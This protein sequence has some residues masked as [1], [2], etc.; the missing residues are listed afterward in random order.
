MSGAG[1]TD[2]PAPAPDP[3]LRDALEELVGLWR[4]SGALVPHHGAVGELVDAA[5]DLMRRSGSEARAGTAFEP[6][7]AVADLMRMRAARGEGGPDLSG[8]TPPVA[9]TQ[10]AAD[11]AARIAPLT[12]AAPPARPALPATPV[13]GW[14]AQDL[15]DAA[16]RFD[17]PFADPELIAYIL[18]VS[19]NA[20]VIVELRKAAYR[21]DRQTRRALFALLGALATLVRELADGPLKSFVEGI[22]TAS[23]VADIVARHAPQRTAKPGR[24]RIDI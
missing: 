14:A 11:L 15:A 23:L 10:S 17:M 3:M 24:R 21:L 13:N 4:P 5:N 1:P 2:P 8:L 7:D 18:A 6:L 22:D 19:P 20:A 12:P 16:A 9:P